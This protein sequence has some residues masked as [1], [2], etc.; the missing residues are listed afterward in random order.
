MKIFFAW[1]ALSVQ[2]ENRVVCRLLT[3]VKAPTKKGRKREKRRVTADGDS[4]SWQA[5]AEAGQSPRG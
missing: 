2:R 5:T 4:S 1:M 3:A